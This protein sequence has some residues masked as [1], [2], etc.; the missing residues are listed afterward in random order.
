[1]SPVIV[2]QTIYNSAVK[3][4]LSDITSVNKLSSKT[5]RILGKFTSIWRHS[6]LIF[7][8]NTTDQLYLSGKNLNM[9]RGQ[10]MALWK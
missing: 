4:P 8:Q 2:L 1:M 3:Y 9:S 10:W 5:W 7:M 6:F